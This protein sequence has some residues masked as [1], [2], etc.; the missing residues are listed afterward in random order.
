MKGD[1][2]FV[3]NVSEDGKTITFEL[4]QGAKFASGNPVR[5]EDVVFSFKR[6]IVLKKA[7]AFI[8][9]QFGWNSENIDQMVSTDA[10]NIS[11]L[12]ICG[13]FRPRKSFW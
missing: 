8:L 3:Q 5:P 1:E 11:M 9:A 4:R 6:V 10:I 7:P 13:R 12:P 2:A